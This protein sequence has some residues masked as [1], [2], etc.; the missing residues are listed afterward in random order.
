MHVIE[1]SDLTKRFGTLVAV[2]HVSFSV[3]E[4]EIFGFLGPNGAGKTTTINMLTTLLNPTE[5]SAKVGGFDVKKQDGKVREIV[6][7]V[8]QDITVDDDLTGMENMML[9]AKLY[10]VPTEVARERIREA[11]GLVGLSDAANRR[12]ET[13]SGG[14]RK[15]LELAEGLIHYPKVLFLDEPT[16]GLDVQT[17]VV[18]WDYIKKLRDEHRITMFLTTHYMEEA[19]IL[20]DRIAIIDHGK[21]VALDTPQNL[22]DSLG[23]DIIELEFNRKMD[24]QTETLRSLPQVKDVK[25]IGDMYRIKVSKG[26][27]A[28]PEI[29]EN[30]LK[31]NLRISRVSLVKP[32]L[33][34]VY[35]EYTG[36]SLRE[37]QGETWEI[38]RRMRTLRRIR[39]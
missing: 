27:K 8:P 34:Q 23:G 28:L 10:H 18:M 3:E 30:M 32:T 26:E 16:L 19:D 15:R 6:G 29:M 39:G 21:I 13:Y 1:A 14:M 17:R 2:D 33:D 31:M 5:G 36:R 20:C 12:V 22:K 4:G 11:L 25:K 38:W 37:T 7:L 24:D 35:L 9:Q